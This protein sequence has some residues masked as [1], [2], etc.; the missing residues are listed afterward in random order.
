M[1]RRLGHI[2]A[3]VEYAIRL[4]NGVGIVA[5]E[6]AAA[7][8]FQ[9]AADVGNPIAQ[10]R[11]ARLLATGRGIK[12]DHVAAAKWHLLAKRAGKDDD[13]LDQMVAGLTDE[14]RQTALASAQRWP[15]AD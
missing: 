9:R 10:N 15:A 11:L 4:F 1:V 7:A 13:F 6:T 3:Q 2:P 5:N 8:W 12:E 14:E